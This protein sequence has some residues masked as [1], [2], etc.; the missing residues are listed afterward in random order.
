MDKAVGSSKSNRLDRVL[1]IGYGNTL[2]GDDGAGVVAAER[3][4]AQLGDRA[5]VLTSHQL[6]PE[7]ACDM[8]R[9]AKV[10]FVD[11]TIDAAPGQV[12]VTPVDNQTDSHG[13]TAHHLTPARLL[14]MV[15]HLFGVSVNGYI[16]AVGVGSMALGESLS[17]AVERALPEMIR[18]IVEL[19]E[20][21][22]VSHA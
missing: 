3:L 17:P 1:I 19:I 7:M 10:V 16:V 14:V 2:R 22:Q 11:A 15:R 8:D 6:L 20:V 21:R 9:Y 18:R 5:D 12:T 4:A 13:P